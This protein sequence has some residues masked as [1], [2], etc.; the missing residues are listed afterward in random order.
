MEDIDYLENYHYAGDF[1]CEGCKDIGNLPQKCDCGGL[2]HWY[3][4][5]YDD[6]DSEYRTICDKCKSISRFVL[7]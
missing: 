1:E 4:Y 6:I 5:H 7:L 3:D 2:R